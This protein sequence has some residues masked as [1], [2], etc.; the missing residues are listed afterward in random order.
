MWH[1]A[2]KVGRKTVRRETGVLVKP[3]G[4]SAKKAEAKAR[5]TAELME[6]GAKGTAPVDK[7]LD[8]DASL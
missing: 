6:R 4:M 2:W 5:E 8:A 3:Q 7:L 1:A